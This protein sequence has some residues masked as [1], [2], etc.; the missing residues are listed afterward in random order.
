MFFRFIVIILFFLS[1]N[2]A[3]VL[4][5]AQAVTF[6]HDQLALEASGK[7]HR[8][9]I[10]IA[11]TP[12]QQELGLMHRTKFADN[13]GMLFINDEERIMDM[14]MKNTLISLDMLFID[15]RGKVVYIAPRTT[16]LSLKSIGP[17]LPVKAV[18][19]LKGGVCQKLGIQAGDRVI[20]PFFTP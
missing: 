14:W 7:R 5:Q 11:Q 20:H 18:L 1:F 13:Q 3:S 8:F 2:A 19:E 10:E 15:K 17:G 4:A 16:P 6:K 9:T 12:Q